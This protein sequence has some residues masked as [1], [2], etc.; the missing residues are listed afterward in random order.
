[1]KMGKNYKKRKKNQK[2]VKI[3]QTKKNTQ[4]Q[5]IDLFYLVGKV[6]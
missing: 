4:Q 6:F 3:K 5:H 2:E 1:M